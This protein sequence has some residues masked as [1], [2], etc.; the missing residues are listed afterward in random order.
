MKYVFK[1]VRTGYPKFKCRNF[2]G[3]AEDR[4]AER[5][6]FRSIVEKVAKKRKEEFYSVV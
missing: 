6:N 3:V 2:G 5:N 1:T 4:Q